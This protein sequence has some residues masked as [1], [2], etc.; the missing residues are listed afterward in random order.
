MTEEI[1]FVS[2]ARIIDMNLAAFVRCYLTINH[3]VYGEISAK[4]KDRV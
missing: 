4:Y 1:I 3:Q 2:M